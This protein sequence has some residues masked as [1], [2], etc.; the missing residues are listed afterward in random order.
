PATCR[1][2]YA[3]PI[4]V[5]N[6]GTHRATAEQHPRGMANLCRLFWDN[7]PP[8]RVPEGPVPSAGWQASR[9]HHPVLVFQAVRD[10]PALLTGEPNLD[11]QDRA[12]AP[13]VRTVLGEQY[14][15]RLKEFIELR[16]VPP[17]PQEPVDAPAEDALVPSGEHLLKP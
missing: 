3:A 14:R 13:A 15:P 17:V 12:A 10:S 16:P 7:L 9:S 1:R 2:L 4:P 8:S 11:G 6:D 5:V